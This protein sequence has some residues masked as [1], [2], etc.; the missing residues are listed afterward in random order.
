MQPGRTDRILKVQL[1]CDGV[2]VVGR[3]AASDED[4]IP[5]VR[6]GVFVLEEE[7]V[8]DAV[9]AES[10]GLDHDAEWP[11][12]LLFNHEVLL[13]A[14]LGAQC[15]QSPQSLSAMRARTGAH[16]QRSGDRIHA[17]STYSLEEM[18]QV[19]TRLVVNLLRVKPRARSH[20]HAHGPSMCW[21]LGVEWGLA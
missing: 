3:L 12:K 11:G 13:A 9:V 18:E 14:N 7:E 6:V 1:T 15:C 20:A 5:L 21:C 10:R 19:L 4:D 8:V 2:S 16:S 17:W